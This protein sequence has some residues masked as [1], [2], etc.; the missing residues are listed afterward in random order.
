MCLEI[1]ES[2]SGEMKCIFFS[3]VN[4]HKRV[5]MAEE[6]LS[7]QRGKLTH[8]GQL[9]SLIIT[10]SDQYVHKVAGLKIILGSNSLAFTPLSL[11]GSLP[12]MGCSLKFSQVTIFTCYNTVSLEDWAVTQWKFIFNAL[13]C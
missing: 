4:A 9:L 11:N 3:G 6:I 5:C 1:S 2:R 8:P 12:L 10:T 7:N 13:L